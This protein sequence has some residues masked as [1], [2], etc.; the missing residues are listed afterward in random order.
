MGP[1]LVGDFEEFNYYYYCYYCCRSMKAR[2]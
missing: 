1:D 2:A